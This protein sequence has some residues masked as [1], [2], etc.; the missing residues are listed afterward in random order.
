MQQEVDQTFI[1][2]PY[3]MP[4]NQMK[5]AFNCAEIQSCIGQ[6]FI[7]LT[8]VPDC[9]ELLDYSETMSTI[10]FICA[11]IHLVIGSLVIIVV[12]VGLIRKHHFT[13]FQWT[14]LIMLIASSVVSAT[15][16]IDYGKSYSFACSFE[17]SLET[18][19]AII[20]YFNINFL[21]AWQLYAVTE[22]LFEFAIN[23]MLPTEKIK[24]RNKK[25]YIFIWT[26]SIIVWI[27]YTSLA[28]YFGN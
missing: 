6:S 15:N 24:R 26:F 1:I 28:C 23:Q 25:I 7:G 14:L 20:M 3:N 17:N 8:F 2:Y 21:V 4:V 11:M 5:E 13:C 10:Y 18:G 9:D 19:I 22:D 12:L 27:F 16:S